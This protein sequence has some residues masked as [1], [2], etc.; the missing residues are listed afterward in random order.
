MRNSISVCV[1][2]A[3]E[4]FWKVSSTNIFTFYL[5]LI[6]IALLLNHCRTDVSN[7]LLTQPRSYTKIYGDRAFAVCTPRT[8]SLLPYAIRKS[9]TVLSFKNQ[10]RHTYLLNSLT[11]VGCSLE[12]FNSVSVNFSIR[13][14]FC[15]S[16]IFYDIVKHLE[17]S[18]KY[19]I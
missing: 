15:N 8:W 6:I 16:C 11:K 17:L 19:A 2:T 13:W 12:I 3:L 18:C 7:E 5:L 9:D 1:F 4:R 10:L 14:N